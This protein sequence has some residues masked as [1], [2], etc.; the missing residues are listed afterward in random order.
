M[1][2]GLRAVTCAVRARSGRTAGGGPGVRVWR[3]R[4]AGRRAPVALRA[5]FLQDDKRG[6]A[7]RQARGPPQP[8]P[9]PGN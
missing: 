6:L 8:T 7:P 2:N 4:R 3:T 9:P 5:P 1:L